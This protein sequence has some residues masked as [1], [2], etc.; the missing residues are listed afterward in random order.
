MSKRILNNE[1]KKN[2]FSKGGNIIYLIFEKLKIQL[3]IN[4]KTY[5]KYKI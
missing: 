2:F 5:S 3:Q 1:K 4:F